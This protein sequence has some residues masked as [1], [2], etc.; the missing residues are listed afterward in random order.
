[1]DNFK[2]YL[3]LYTKKKILRKIEQEVDFI[4]WRNKSS[5]FKLLITVIKKS[6]I[7]KKILQNKIYFLNFYNSY[8]NFK[9]FQKNVKGKR[10]YH[11]LSNKIINCWL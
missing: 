1:M 8:S 7:E 4:F 5:P 11:K 3:D 10:F 2:N 9:Y 6:L